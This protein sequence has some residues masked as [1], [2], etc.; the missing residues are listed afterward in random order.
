[1]QASPAIGPHAL[2]ELAD[3]LRQ[4]AVSQVFVLAD[5]NTIRLC[6]PRLREFLP[7][8]HITIEIPDGEEHKVLA[9]CETVWEVL[10][11]AHADRFAVLVN[12]GGGVVTDLGGF[13]A[14]LYKRGIRFVQVPTT[15][16]AQV[17]A[18][19]GG[20]TGIDFQ[21]FKNQLGVFQAPAAVFIEP[22]FLNSLEPRQLKSGY[23]EVVKHW[24]IADAA[25][26][27][28][29]RRTGFF[30]DEWGPII[31]ESVRP[32]SEL[33]PPIRW[34]VG[35]ARCSTLVIPWVTPSKATCLPS[36]AARFCTAKRWPLE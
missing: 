12:L 13:C 26:F 18:S 30:V 11:E 36:P 35:C 9:T 29:H 33:W 2:I 7:D 3:L 1:M 16:L 4:P 14:A 23:A 15:L 22:R 10:T 19:V 5:A 28:H 8:N 27:D 24:L 32:R 17:D 20:K 25:A 31:H 34:K 21:N 6:Y